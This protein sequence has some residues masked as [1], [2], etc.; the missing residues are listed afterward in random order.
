[1]A[2]AKLISTRLAVCPVCGREAR[3]IASTSDEVLSRCYACGDV[4]RTPQPGRVVWSAES[5][6][7][8]TALAHPAPAAEEET[9]VA[10]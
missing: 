1:M 2:G 7:R 10:S 6:V 5:A 4:T 3:V 8:E 9:L